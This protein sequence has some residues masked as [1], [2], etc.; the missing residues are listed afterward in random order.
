MSTAAGSGAVGRVAIGTH[1]KSARRQP[2]QHVA[3]P[4]GRRDPH[5]D[6]RRPSR[7]VAGRRQPRRSG[8]LHDAD[9]GRGSG[10]ADDR[11]RRIMGVSRA[12]PARSALWH[13]SRDCFR[14]RR[15]SAARP[16]LGSRRRF[17]PADHFRLFDSD[18]RSG[19]AHRDVGGLRHERESRHPLSLRFL[20]AR[21]Q[22]ASGRAQRRSEAARGRPRLSLLASGNC[23]SISCCLRPCPS[24]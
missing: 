13:D 14:H 4:A 23:G 9:G 24:S 18:G 20:S 22:Y 10:R 7:P 17:R 3:R 19:A 5:R 6:A 8:P 1:G 12:E 11:E 2:P 15:R 21:H 16:L